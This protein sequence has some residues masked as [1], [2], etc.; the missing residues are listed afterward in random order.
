MIRQNCDRIVITT[1]HALLVVSNLELNLLYVGF[2]MIRFT[3]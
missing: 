2:V 1:E 3:T